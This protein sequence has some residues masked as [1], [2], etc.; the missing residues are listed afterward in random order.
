MPELV[1]NGAGLARIH[2]RANDRKFFCYFTGF[3]EGIVSSGYIEVGEVEPLVAECEEFV[4]RVADAD[5]NEIIQDFEA[6]LLECDSIKT[7]CEY[8][9]PEIDPECSKSSLNRFLG[10][11]RGIVC[12]GVIALDEAS[13]LVARIDESPALL[14]EIGVR[15]IY[16]SCRDAI[17]DGYIDSDE[18]LAICNA[19]GEIIG[20][21]YGDTGIAQTFGVANFDEYQIDCVNSDLEGATVVLTGLFHETPRSLFEDTV[22]G[23]GATVAKAVTK[24]TDFVIVG[25]EASRDWIEMN[26]GT[27]IRKA[28]EL[29]LKTGRPDFISEMQLRRHLN[30]G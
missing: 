6:D 14:A 27:K 28:Q 4:R 25:G 19:I 26:R 17:E 20:D 1:H 2:K 13:E 11:C 16:V 3:L 8:R 7:A 15:N 22:K 12:D 9:I 10:F 21:S 5:A 30:R 29:R 24:K 23:L 18:S